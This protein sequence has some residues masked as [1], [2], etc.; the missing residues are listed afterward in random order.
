MFHLTRCLW[1]IQTGYL[2]SHC[3]YQCLCF[4]GDKAEWK[5]FQGRSSFLFIIPKSW[6]GNTEVSIVSVYFS[7]FIRAKQVF[8]G[9]TSKD[10]MCSLLRFL[11]FVSQTVSTFW[12][13]YHPD[14]PPTERSQLPE[15]TAQF[16]CSLQQKLAFHLVLLPSLSKFSSLL[17]GGD[18]GEFCIISLSLVCFCLT[19]ATAYHKSTSVCLAELVSFS[20]FFSSFFF[21]YVLTPNET[22]VT[23]EKK[24][25]QRCEVVR[26]QSLYFV[27][28]ELSWH[29]SCP[30]WW[31]EVWKFK[32][33][34]KKRKRLQSSESVLIKSETYWMMDNVSFR[35]HFQS[36]V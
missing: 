32:K 29:R 21:D 15:D 20:F 22:M 2:E 19:A 26:G 7:T 31:T 11:L 33:K 4:F 9:I 1:W 27:E 24:P 17:L 23:L 5:S 8:T 18:S 36:I 30:P 6:K 34:E 25:E 35:V 16:T 28:A 3:S 10:R 13:F 12:V 14:C